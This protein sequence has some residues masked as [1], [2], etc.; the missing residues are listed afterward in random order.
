MGFVRAN[1]LPILKEHQRRPWYG[2]AL[3]LGQADVCFTSSSLAAMAR[4]VGVS[5]APVPA[6]TA[7]HRPDLAEKGYL[8]RESLFASLGF[9]TSLALDISDSEG[10]EV[11]F[12]LNSDV[13]PEELR[14]RFD[15]VFDHG[16]MEHV[17]HVPNCLA[18]IHALLREG[19]RVVHSSPTSNYVDHGFYMFSP[20]LFHD[21]YS[22]NGWEIRDIKVARF[23]PQRQELEA[24]FF[25]D[26][27]PGLFDA[28][29]AGGLGD[30]AYLTICVAQK[31]AAS[32]S[33]VVPQ[34]GYYRRMV[35]WTLEEEPA[36]L[37]S[38]ELTPPFPR[39]ASHCWIADLSRHGVIDGDSPP[40]PGRSCLRLFEDEVRLGP[41]HSVHAAIRQTGQ[42]RYSHWG[43]VLYFSPSDNSDP[44][45]NRRRY[46]VR[47]R[48][49]S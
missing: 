19:G 23:H 40:E 27:G 30:G 32:T 10:A 47:A 25:A 20:T 42:G 13:L 45:R 46:L 12:D 37:E 34:Q 15:A 5:L 16:T 44:N 48:R 11:Q 7:S 28:V 9:G 21:F 18:N 4:S 33:R 39:D 49:R 43:S 41:P 29:S 31:L 35:D 36:G 1:M 26:Y 2:D 8:S 17:F 14:G 6:P 38:I 3:C 22:A 24:P